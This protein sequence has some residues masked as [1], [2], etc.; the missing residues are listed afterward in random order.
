MGSSTSSVND[1]ERAKKDLENAQ[2]HLK[3]MK[4]Q[5]AYAKK[6]GAYARQPKNHHRGGGQ[7]GTS[8]DANVWSAEEWVKKAKQQLAD[9][10]KRK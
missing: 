5:R 8:Y 9:A 2:N 6:N 7:M 1:I 3:A 4:E 10:K